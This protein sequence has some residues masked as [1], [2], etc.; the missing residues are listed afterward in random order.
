VALINAGPQGRGRDDPDGSGLGTLPIPRRPTPLV[1]TVRQLSAPA[2]PTRKRIEWEP[3]EVS[4]NRPVGAIAV[5]ARTPPEVAMEP[6]AALGP[7]DRRPRV[8]LILP[9]SFNDQTLLVRFSLRPNEEGAPVTEV[10]S[11]LVV[12]D[13]TLLERAW[14]LR[15]PLLA[16]MALATIASAAYR[17]GPGRRAREHR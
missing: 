5:V 14:S 11:N 10:V 13:P 17:S 12:H 8:R 3:F 15:W 6:I 4:T 9:A 1:L 16:L 2:T 7:L